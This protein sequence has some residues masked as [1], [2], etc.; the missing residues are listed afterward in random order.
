MRKIDTWLS[1]QF[2]YTLN[3]ML[4]WENFPGSADMLVKIFP[5]FFVEIQWQLRKP[6][7]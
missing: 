7:M 4:K 1:N 6:D 2:A 5:V 3:R